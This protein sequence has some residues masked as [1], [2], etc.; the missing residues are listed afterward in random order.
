M[1]V[2][3]KKVPSKLFTQ[4]A[5]SLS[6]QKYFAGQFIWL[7]K[8]MTQVSRYWGNLANWWNCNG[9]ISVDELRDKVEK[10]KLKRIKQNSFM[11]C[12]WIYQTSRYV[13]NKDKYA[14][15]KC[16]ILFSP[17][18]ESYNWWKKISIK[19]KVREVE[20]SNLSCAQSI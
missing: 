1:F 17:V 3:F 9:T 18:T 13:Q 16:Y 14:R 11:N 19:L 15:E 12:L 10:K 8:Y 4:L 7:R 6:K 20:T 2:M 5:F